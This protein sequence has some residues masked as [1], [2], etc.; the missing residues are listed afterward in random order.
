[1]SL[2]H[3]MRKIMVTFPGWKKS[4]AM[5]WIDRMF[6]N[7]PKH[8]SGKEMKDYPN[9]EVGGDVLCARLE[10]EYPSRSDYIQHDK[11]K[12]ESEFPD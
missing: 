2:D 11:S 1:M 12:P 3:P 8:W 9:A 4:E 10:V 6:P 5:P 7:V